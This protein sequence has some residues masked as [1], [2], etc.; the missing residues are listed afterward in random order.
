MFLTEYILSF[1]FKTNKR[2]NKQ[3]NERTNERTNKMTID[4]EKK[5]MCTLEEGITTEEDH[6]L[7]S[8]NNNNNGDG[9]P[10]ETVAMM[11][12]PDHVHPEGNASPEQIARHDDPQSTL[13]I[14]EQITYWESKIVLLKENIEDY[15]E[16]LKKAPDQMYIRHLG[17]DIF[18]IYKEINNTRNTVR[19]L[20]APVPSST[21]RLEGDRESQSSVPIEEQVAFWES[22]IV[23]LK[24]KIDEVIEILKKGPER[25]YIRDLGRIIRGFCKDIE[26]VR[27]TIHLLKNPKPLFACVKTE[28]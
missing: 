7:P 11:V 22:E 10:L 1:P 4:R 26:K 19:R 16:V 21:G 2:T 20:R 12:D 15:F 17:L 6:L 8:N 28:K 3:T 5:Q 18:D 13:T 27:E 9:V 23:F 14:E 25:V 24:E